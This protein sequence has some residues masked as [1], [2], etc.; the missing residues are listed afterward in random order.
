MVDHQ[1]RKR[2]CVLFGKMREAQWRDMSSWL[3]SSFL[4]I[5]ETVMSTSSSP[6][7]APTHV[8]HA[9]PQ[10]ACTAHA[11][12]CDALCTPKAQGRAS[13]ID[14]SKLIHK[15]FETEHVL[16]CSQDVP[17]H[18]FVLDSNKGYGFQ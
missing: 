10:H 5:A 17:G 9:A 11:W 18:N 15:L 4:H 16:L 2:S 14:V 7:C 1:A 12:D 6:S 3:A 13:T 8:R